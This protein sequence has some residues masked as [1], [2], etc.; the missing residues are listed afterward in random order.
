MRAHPPRRRRIRADR[1][2]KTLVVRDLARNQ[3][4]LDL[5]LEPR[6]VERR[7]AAARMQ[8][9]GIEYVGRVGIEPD[10]IGRRADGQP[11]LRQSQDFGRAQRQRAKQS[12]AATARRRT[13]AASP[14]DSIVSTPIAPASASA[15]GSRLVSTSCGS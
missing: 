13:R 4:E 5:T 9:R 3:R 12:A 6:A 15:N 10:Q 8:S 11:S 14:A 1:F 2:K 7:V